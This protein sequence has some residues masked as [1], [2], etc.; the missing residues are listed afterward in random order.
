ML[1]HQGK[2]FVRR[3]RARG[4]KGEDGKLPPEPEMLDVFDANTLK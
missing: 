4:E 2:L 3:N 1:Y